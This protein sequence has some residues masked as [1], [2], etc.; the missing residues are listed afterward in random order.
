MRYIF[1]TAV[2]SAVF[3]YEKD[4]T[5]TVQAGKMDCFFQ[6]VLVNELIDIEYQVIDSSHGDHDISFQL[7]DPLGRSVVADYKKPDNAHR[8]TSL[9]EGDYKFCFDNTFSTFSEKTVFFDLLID[10]EEPE[11]K[12]YDDDKELELGTSAETYMMRVKDISDSVSKLKD[13]VST[14]RRLQELLSAHEAR[15]RNLAEDMCDRVL[16]WSMGQIILMTVVGVT[17]VYFLK[18]LFQDPNNSNFQKMVPNFMS[19]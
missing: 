14:A 9:V 6:K 16:K 8:H 13:N 11:P 1:I 4:M 10:T 7:V 5:F 2:F 3:A 18:S 17:Q 19:Q 15:D 12:D